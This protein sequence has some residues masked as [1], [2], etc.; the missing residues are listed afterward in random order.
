M[1]AVVCLL[2]SISSKPRVANCMQLHQPFAR[3]TFLLFYRPDTARL[4]SNLSVSSAGSLAH[5]ALDT[6]P[7]VLL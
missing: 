7:L 2:H 4:E 6:S 5:W 1:D 3:R